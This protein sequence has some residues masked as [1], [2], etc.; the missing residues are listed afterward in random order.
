[1]A[2]D[3][4]PEDTTAKGEEGKGEEAVPRARLD[5]ETARRHKAEEKVK[6]LEAAAA[7]REKKVLEESNNF[8]ELYGKAE[9]R[10]KLADE[11]EL[12]VKEYYDAETADL[13][14]EQKALIPEGPAHKQL[15]WIKKAK[16]AGVFGKQSQPDKTF[17]GKPKSGLPADKW[18][19][20]LKSGDARIGELTGPQYVEWKAHN[21]RVPERV[22]GGF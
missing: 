15:A 10:A 2:D 14:D 12:S 3:K 8:K 11:M 18:Y 20:E 7:E 6:A 9:P 16:A 22:A 17:N 19:L 21:G 4:K 5:A 1:M 13:T